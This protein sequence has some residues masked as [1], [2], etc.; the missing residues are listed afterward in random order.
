MKAFKKQL[1]K[2]TDSSPALTTTLI[3][4]GEE[5]DDAQ[6]VRSCGA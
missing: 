3:L 6:E 5:Y 1:A 2:L 4:D